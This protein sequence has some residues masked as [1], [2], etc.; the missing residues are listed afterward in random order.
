MSKLVPPAI[1]Q[2]SAS[3]ETGSAASVVRSAPPVSAARPR[4]RWAAAVAVGCALAAPFG[5]LLSYVSFLMAYLGLFFYAL[6]GL[7]IGASVYRVA[8][9]C[10]PVRK[11]HVLVGTTL[12]VLVGWGLSIRGEIVGLPRDIANLAVEARTRLPEGMNKDQYMN[13]IEDQVRR[14]LS[15]R[16]PPGGAIGYIR[17]IT[18]SG[19]FPKGTFEG[20][21]RELARPQRRWV[22]AI[23]VVLSIVLFSFGIASMT[24]PLASPLPS[25]HRPSSEPST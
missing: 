2:P 19:R 13:S 20:V 23:R 10:R 6:F 12:I 8:A 18:D 25:P 22:W 15:D 3:R 7:V 11:A 21:N 1:E 16:Y 14:H 24:W 4:G 9:R 17:W 5:V